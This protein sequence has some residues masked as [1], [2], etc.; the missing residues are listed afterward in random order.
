VRATFSRISLWIWL[1]AATAT[2]SAQQIQYAEPISLAPNGRAAQF[3]AY[4]RR[5]A[6]NLQDNDRLLSKLSAQR[7]QELQTYRLLRGSLDGE[8][9]SW[10]RLTDSPAG[11]EGAIWDGHDL[12]AVTTYSR[13]EPYLTKP[14]A[15]SPNQ[16]VVYRLS[17]AKDVLP[18]DFCAL[19][20]D[21]VVTRKATALD[22][23]RA[24]VADLQDTAAGRVSQQIE[25]SL[26]ADSAFANA[27]SQDPTAAML[28]R[29]NI[30]EGIFSEQ[31]G[32]LVLATDLRVMPASSDPFTSTAATTLLEQVGK[33]RAANAAVRARGLAHLMTGKNLDGTTAGIAY[34]GSVCEQERGASLSERSYGTTISALVMAH[35]LGHN[36]GAPH[37]GDGACASVGGGFIMAPSVSGFA[38]F[39]QCSLDVMHTTL[40]SASCVTPADY[41]DV[42]LS[43]TSSTSISA[44]GG[45][46][47][48]LPY[49]VRSIGTNAA[50]DVVFT[51]TVPDN[52]GASFDAISAEGGSC[53]VSGTTAT[54][55]FGS[56][57]AGE[58]RNVS[59]TVHP[60][61]GGSIVLRARVT[62]GNDPLSANNSRDISVSI[63]SGIDAAVS[64][65]TDVAE[66]PIG[67]SLQVHADL[68]SLRALPVRNAMLTVSL[69]QGVSAASM[70]GA[71]C[72]TSQFSVV[73]SVAELA[74]GSSARLTV[75]ASADAA[76]P[77][78]ANATVTASGDG[79]LSNN[80]ANASAWVQAER[81]IELTAGPAGVDLAVGESYEIP[82]LVRSRGP[83][84]TGAVF[85]SLSVPASSAVVESLDAGGAACV[86]VDG[87]SW[88]CELGVV[89]SGDSRL[90]RLRLHSDVPANIAVTA[91]AD[92]DADGYLPNN[93]TG[94]QLRVDNAVDL[95]LLLAAG[96]TGVE[97]AD[98]DGQVTVRSGGRNPA[99]GATLDID[100]NTA[101]KLTTAWVDEGAECA[102][103]SATR[104]RCTLPTLARGA[105]VFVNY[106]ASFAEPGSY[107]VKFT[108]NTP[109]DT[110]PQNDTL[111][112]P[113]LVRPYNDIG[114]AGS[115]D[116][117]GFV[118]GESRAGTFTL[119]TGRRPLASARFTAW[120]YLP[121][122]E[123]TA[124]QAS[125]GQ[126]RVDAGVGG[127]CDFTDLPPDSKLTVSVTWHADAAAPAQDVAVSVSTAGD[128][129]PAN[130]EVRGRAEVLGPTDV[131]LR[132][133]AS[134]SGTSGAMLDY[135]PISVV[136]GAERA[137]GTRLEVQL[138]EQVTLVSISAANAICSGT[139]LLR[140]DFAELDPN[141]TS[142]VNISVRT[143]E[144]GRYRS[145]LKL[146]SLNDNNPTNDSRE[147]A[148][149][150][151]G[152]TSAAAV[153]GGGSAGSGGGGG[154]ELLSLA[155]LALI[156]AVR[157]RGKM[158]G[159]APR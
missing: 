50:D 35:E 86:K 70:P 106:R 25:I 59:A 77:L 127:I 80:S 108:L 67:S 52:M 81:D 62:A 42:S 5:F 141:S 126:C 98:I 152:G 113:I 13:A 94:V 63:R 58:L 95:A 24:L 32:L 117:T 137:V 44:D 51:M 118:I 157:D 116:L 82:F 6:L 78:F 143:G 102:L 11:L 46:P 139:T 21:P 65:D 144:S 158:L 15:V 119:S 103:L 133:D 93:S 149:D 104:A 129:L 74:A 125:A 155:A 151:S 123:V 66:V 100:L 10:V 53:T 156:V 92:T 19:G 111:T 31:V 135:P 109:G 40:A 61:L 7:K 47:F 17:D 124:I 148:L 105:Q 131:E 48:T 83:Q 14:L 72:T 147:V 145:A 28:A 140:C 8:P 84:A 89:P 16:T 2:A 3:D 87:A 60:T 68:R 29:L 36:F 99:Q 120:H 150:I 134:R 153:Q 38:T 26:I 9:G 43:T 132:V 56:I 115:L 71:T 18:Q 90:V 55:N 159:I 73:C 1:I 142:T 146:T 138:P 130:N 97:D 88:R 91:T 45:V 20:D 37:D 85:L 122:F 22:Q 136:N 39:S 34:V 154:F 27:E 49:V 54:C 57:G 30:V 23:Y 96:G 33:Y 114:V 101:G 69:N 41:A 4:G 76:G 107:D 112:R 12:Y 64:V 79:D 75:D 110:A 128:V 121:G